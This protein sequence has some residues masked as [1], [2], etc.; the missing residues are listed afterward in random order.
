MWVG[1]ILGKLPIFFSTHHPP[2]RHIRLKA[3]LQ[4]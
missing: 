4:T 2:M 1:R 3:H